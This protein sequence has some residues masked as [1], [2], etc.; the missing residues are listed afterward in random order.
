MATKKTIPSRLSLKQ[1]LAAMQPVDPNLIYTPDTLGR[2]IGM[3]RRWVMDH[4]IDSGAIEYR[5]EGDFI[6]IPGWIFAQWLV[7]NLR[8]RDQWKKEGRPQKR[9]NVAGEE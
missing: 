8:K 5:K 6:G 4:L 1:R 9:E 3:S 7:S 2:A